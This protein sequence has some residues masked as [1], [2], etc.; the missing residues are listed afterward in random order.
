MM[1]GRFIP[2]VEDGH[3]LSGIPRGYAATF[4]HRNVPRRKRLLVVQ[5]SGVEKVLHSRSGQPVRPAFP[6]CILSP[7]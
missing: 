6:V 7:G 4:R 2:L 3:R 1:A 5:N